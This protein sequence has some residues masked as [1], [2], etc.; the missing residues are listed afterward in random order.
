MSAFQKK[1]FL[2]WQI[3]LL[4]NILSSIGVVAIATACNNS[5][6]N[7]LRKE[8]DSLKLIVNEKEQHDSIIAVNARNE[9]MKKQNDSVEK[10][11]IVPTIKEKQKQKTKVIPV[12]TP[13]YNPGL[14]TLDY[15]VYPTQK[16]EPTLKQND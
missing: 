3:R 7:Q 6:N 8:N 14:P 2:E 5:N 12:I 15:G 13:T 16:V 10:I 4:K 1:L 11:K 9:S